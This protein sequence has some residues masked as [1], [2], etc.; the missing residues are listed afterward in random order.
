MKQIGKVFDYVENTLLIVGLLTSTFILF[1]NVIMRYFFHSG[2][3]W[4]EELARYAIIW[5]VCGGCGAAV[6]AGIHMRITAMLDVM[7][8]RKMRLVFEILVTI[9]S[10]SFGIFM[11]VVG[12]RLTSS[13]IT[14]NQLSSAME[15]PL[16]WI[17]SAIPFG[18]LSMT[19]R[20]IEI[21]VGQV[22]EFVGKGG[23]VA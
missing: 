23:A 9:A 20:Y 14:N 19:V 17:Y 5:V 15:I 4:A 21:L 16:W 12:V 13:M 2:I 1:A 11:L 10:M 18:G 6:R 22:K 3:V 8:N 7:K